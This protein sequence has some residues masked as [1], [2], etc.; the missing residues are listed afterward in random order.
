MRAVGATEALARGRTCYDH[1]AGRLGVALFDAMSER[2]LLETSTG[3]ALTVSGLEWL[4]DLGIDVDAL[5]SG[6]R[7]LTRT[8]VDWT[9]RRP[10]LAGAAG[11]ALCSRFVE[12]GWVS[13]SRRPRAVDVTALGRRELG[14]RLGDADAWST[15]EPSLAVAARPLTPALVRPGLV[16]TPT[17][18]DRCPA[19]CQGRSHGT[20][21]VVQ[22]RA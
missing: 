7:P 1:L 6:R 15:T 3:I 5:R 21:R 13:R 16:D 20:H 9:E 22:G 12:L 19:R 17:F 14:R 11:G 18:V 4:T 10:H 8:C 2:G